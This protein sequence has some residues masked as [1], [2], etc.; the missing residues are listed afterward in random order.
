MTA[1]IHERLILDDEETSMAFCPPLPEEHTGIYELSP[2]EVFRDESDS[3][4]ESTGLL[5]PV[6]RGLG[7]SRKAAFT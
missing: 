5:A 4:L 3:I 1:Q 7:K 2:D 6:T